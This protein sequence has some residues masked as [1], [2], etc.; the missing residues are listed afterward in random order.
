MNTKMLSA[1]AIAGALSAGCAQWQREEG[2]ATAAPDPRIKCAAEQSVC[3]ITV[4]VKDC[5][6]SVDPDEKRVASRPGGATM[7]WTIRDSPGV[8][9]ARNG[10][11]FKPRIEGDARRVFRI[12]DRSLASPT[13]AMHNDT[14]PGKYPYT[15]HVID[16][17]KRCDPHD[18]GVVNEM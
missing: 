5:R 12:E 1:L 9:F 3:H 16:N 6:V 14:T 10:I 13:L 11:T 7:L 18:P 15:V 4:R 2:K 8:V 17:G